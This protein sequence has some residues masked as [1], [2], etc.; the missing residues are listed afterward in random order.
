MTDPEASRPSP[1]PLKAV[2]PG[3][4]RFMV[5]GEVPYFLIPT[6][7]IRWPNSRETLPSESAHVRADHYSGGLLVT[8]WRL[9]LFDGGLKGRLGLP[10]V[11]DI[12]QGPYHAPRGGSQF[13]ELPPFELVLDL[14]YAQYLIPTVSN[15]VPVYAGIAARRTWAEGRFKTLTGAGSTPMSRWGDVTSRGSLQLD[16]AMIDMMWNRRNAAYQQGGYISRIA[17]QGTAMLWVPGWVGSFTVEYPERVDG[18]PPYQDVCAYL[19]PRAQR[20]RDEVSRLRSL[21]SNG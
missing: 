4:A 19:Q 15:L 10:Y 1:E 21:A 13:S 5:T 8:N 3:A 14:D 18:A 7:K 20:L 6:A 17:G 16:V 11:E 2:P 9:F 12:D